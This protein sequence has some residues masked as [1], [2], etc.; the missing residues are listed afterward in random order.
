MRHVLQALGPCRARFGLAERKKLGP[1]RLRR[2]CVSEPFLIFFFIFSQVSFFVCYILIVFKIHYCS[3]KLYLSVPIG[4]KN[5]CGYAGELRTRADSVLLDRL[6]T[7]QQKIEHGFYTCATVPCLHEAETLYVHEEKRTKSSIQVR[8]AHW[9]F[10]HIYRI[11]LKRGCR[12]ISS[13]V[14]YCKYFA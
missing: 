2:P 5:H 12:L 14:R 1:T 4:K 6:V 10:A 13:Q 9:Y 11:L 7:N 8:H 3:I